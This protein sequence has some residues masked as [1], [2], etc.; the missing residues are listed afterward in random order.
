[1]LPQEG[2]LNSAQNIQY[3]L[4]LAKK[5][6]CIFEKIITAPLYCEILKHTLLPF[7]EEKFPHRFMQDNDP[8]HTS[9]VAQ[10]FFTAHNINWW[11][12]PPE[13]PDMNPIENVWHELKEFIQR[14]VKP[15]TKEELIGTVGRQAVRDLRVATS[16]YLG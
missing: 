15:H 10:Q 11:R 6:L 4:A 2:H 3:G 14:E 9:R 13:S 12:T 5:V 8:K 7:I 1:M 16:L